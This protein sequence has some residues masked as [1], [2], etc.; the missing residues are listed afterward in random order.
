MIAAAACVTLC[1]V[2]MHFAACA[3]AG[4]SVADP[5][6]YYANNV[7]GTVGLLLGIVE[8]GV[9]MLVF[10]STCATYGVPDVSPI[11]EDHPQRP[12]NPYGASKLMV[13][14]MLAETWSGRTAC[15]GSHS[16]ISTPRMPTWPA[17]SASGT[18]PRR[19]SSRSRCRLRPVTAP[20]SRSTGPAI[21]RRTAR[22]SAT[23][24][25]SSISPRPTSSGCAISKLAA[26]ARPSIAENGNGC[27]V[28][29][30]ID[31]VEKV[32]GRAITATSRRRPGDPPALVGSADK[33]RRVLGWTPKFD[34]LDTIVE[35]GLKWPSVRQR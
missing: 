19:T 14:R 31:T 23:P 29:E 18:S 8:A 13:E 26:R 24:S 15:A 17:P 11:T 35:T 33:A 1:D 22:A 2:D 21:R 30:V 10:S 25:T 27:S 16:G 28:R 6:T 5:L 20:A 34:R 9:G 32:T 3:Y 4:E 7:A 12:I